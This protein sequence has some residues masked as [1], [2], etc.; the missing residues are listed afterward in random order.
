[1]M[2]DNL[3]RHLRPQHIMKLVFLR[4]LLVELLFPKQRHSGTGKIRAAF[5]A[6]HLNRPQEH[7]AFHK[8][9]RHLHRNLYKTNT[10]RILAYLPILIINLQLQTVAYFLCMDVL[11]RTR[12]TLRG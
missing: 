12:D 3:E 11:L 8:N 9:V 5:S 6:I 1:M 4:D 10:P 7:T 2:E